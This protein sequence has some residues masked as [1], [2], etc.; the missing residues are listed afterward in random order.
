M[1]TQPELTT[2][3]NAYRATTAALPQRLDARR[4]GYVERTVITSD[5]VRLAARDYGS[6]GASEHTVVLLHG[7][8]LTQA[9]WALQIRHLVR[10]WGNSVRI[11]TYDHRGHGRST[12]A[13]MH[14][15]RID[16]LAADLADVLTALRVTG[17]L[18]LA[19]HSMGGMTALAY[20]GRPAADR[21][22]E[23]QGLVLVATAAGRLAE[24]GLGRLLGTR[25]TDMLFNLV[26]RM[27]RQATDHFSGLVRPVWQGLNKH[28]GAATTGAAAV[29]ASAVHTISLTTAVGFL[30]GL[31]EYDQYHALASISADTV[32]IS[33]GADLATP[34]AHARDL[35]AAIPGATHLHQPNAGHMLVEERPQC[36]SEAI[37][38]VMGLHRRSATR[39]KARASRNSSPTP[40]L[41]AAVC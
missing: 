8:C 11:I 12:G 35:A 32:V 41:A 18:T 14:T 9:S 40:Q 17:P 34:A 31:K 25:A 38:S 28:F 10:R 27:P 2:G 37:D 4:D 19:G 24:R 29:A 7:L 33:G 21:P 22:V 26:H 15:Y 23:A 3:T 36:V 13:D 16:R 5:G 39:T 30:P 20:L 1:F 6:A